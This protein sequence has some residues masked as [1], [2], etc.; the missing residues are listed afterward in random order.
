MYRKVT[1]DMTSALTRS[2][3]KDTQLITYHHSLSH[4]NSTCT[5]T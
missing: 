1:N 5:E 3:T 2:K 4:T